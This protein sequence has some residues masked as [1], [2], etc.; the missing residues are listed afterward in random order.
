MLKFFIVGC[1]R[2]GTT[3]LQQALNRHSRIAIPPETAFFSHFLGYLGHMR[4]MQARHLR[5]INKELQIELPMPAR[6]V[7]TPENARG[8]YE[9]M[10]QL[11]VERLGKSG[12]THVGEKTPYHLLHLPRL[13]QVYPDAKVLLVYRDGRD[14]ALSLSKVPWVPSNVYA[15]FALWLRAYRW[16]RWALGQK[17]LNLLCVRYEDLA[18]DP[19]AELRKV[20]D[21]LGLAYESAMAEGGGNREGVPAWEVAWKARAFEKISTARIGVWKTELSP[22]QV[23]DFERWGGWALSELAYELATD[24][25][26]HFPYGR[27]VRAYWQIL[28]LR[29]RLGYRLLKRTIIPAP[30]SPSLVPNAEQAR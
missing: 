16:H 22:Q 17:N 24:G 2:S 12:V 14:V 28:T 27:V 25:R 6:R 20:A 4:W 30:T 23:R 18:R 1:G 19:E 21:F 13:I 10:M 26:S 3:M 8:V 9:Q 29:T 11:Y 5:W 7:R 15:G